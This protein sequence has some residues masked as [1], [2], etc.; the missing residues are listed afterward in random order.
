MTGPLDLLS[1]TVA[2]SLKQC[3]WQEQSRITRPEG[4]SHPSSGILVVHGV[5]EDCGARPVVGTQLVVTRPRL[6]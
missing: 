1:L 2:Q 6:K 3:G 4:V 5:R